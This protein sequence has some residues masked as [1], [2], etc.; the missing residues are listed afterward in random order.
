MDD[1]H[2]VT[3]ANASPGNLMGSLQPIKRTDTNTNEVDEFV[4]AEEK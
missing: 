4:D 2:H 3:Q 1:D